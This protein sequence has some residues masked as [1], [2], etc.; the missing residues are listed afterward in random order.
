MGFRVKRLRLVGASAATPSYEVSFQPDGATEGYRPLSVIAGPSLTGKTTIV[1]FIAY[2]LGGNYLPPHDEVQARVRGALLELDLDYQPTVIERSAAGSPSEF[3]TVWQSGLEDIGASAEQRLSIEPTGDPAGLSQFVL[4]SSNLDGVRLSDSVVK[5]DTGSGM[6]SI[7][8]LFRI[9]IVTNDR[10][11]SKNLV[12][13]RDHFMV[14]QKYRQTIEVMFGVYDNE[15]AVLAE[16]QRRA[17][18]QRN[19]AQAR[20]EALVIS[21]ER[22]YPDG[23]GVLQ[24]TIDQQSILLADL[25][26]QLSVLDAER[27]TTE[28][29]SD[30]LR[31]ALDLA[32]R[33]ASASRVQ[34]RDRESLLDRL[35]SLR[36]QYVDDRRKLNFLLDAE[37]SFDPLRVTVCPACFNPL[38]PA[39]TIHDGACSLCSHPV[40][41][42]A[43]DSFDSDSEIGRSAETEGE[44]AALA[45][46]GTA[47]ETAGSRLVRA[48]LRAVKSRLSSL[49]E[50]ITRLTVDQTALVREAANAERKAT[51]AAAAVDAIVD[52]PAPWLALRD[53]L[54]NDITTAKLTRQA[55]ET[56]V[57]AWEWVDKGRALV[58]S[59][60]G[61]VDRLSGARRRARPNRD[62]VTR[63]LSDRFAAILADIGYPKLSSAYIGQDFIPY[64]RGLQY[65]NASSGGMVIIALAWNLALWEVAYEQNADAPGLLIIDSPQKNLGHNAGPDDD[66]ADATLVE[67]FYAHAKNWLA[68]DG[69]GAQL[70]VIDNSPPDT[71]ADDVVIR[72]TRRA[73]D[74][75]YGL[76]WDA[77]N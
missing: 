62:A 27:R 34:V 48:E 47:K 46:E 4:A 65:T 7:R 32:Q 52:S 2:C 28:S 59:L 75:P 55:A 57:R 14:K 49:N 60:Q 42:G 51:E 16:R 25:N 41:T 3:A 33:R 11:D 70:I 72:F 54:T 37:A 30:N 53:R 1:D 20:L 43:S 26:A 5:E 69:Q 76:I 71:V 9:F 18:Q 6:L 36:G 8:D 17:I 39:P 13:E 23:P 35:D 61:E 56:G 67:R 74:H 40:H 38:D 64:V 68:H 31:R 10:L 15:E 44:G 58:E 45:V 63:A 77:V 73:E 24:H 66:F 29:A 50:Y 21:A 19:S 22:D 12:Y